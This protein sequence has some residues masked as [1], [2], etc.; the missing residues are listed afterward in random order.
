MQQL[1]TREI[2]DNAMSFD[3]YMD[4]TRKIIAAPAAD[5]IYQNESTH[6][7]TISNL[8]RM[9]KV[10][11]N[12]FINQK[13]YNQLSELKEEWVWI[14]LSEPW[15]GDASWG[16]PALYV[17]STS[18]DLIEFKILLRDEH[19]DIMK[20][21]QTDGTDSIPK[22]ICLRKHDLKELGTWG[23]R[24]KQLHELVVKLKNEP[25]IDYRQSVRQLHSWYEQDMTKMIQ[26]EIIDCVKLWKEVI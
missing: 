9:Q 16:T 21:Y 3:D 24:P 22:L 12:I 20:R 11:D 15:C 10:L 19:P 17:I 26:E 8:K 6:R 18:S 5:S 4:L 25:G 14:V 1:I 23:P 7:Y 2:I 13:L